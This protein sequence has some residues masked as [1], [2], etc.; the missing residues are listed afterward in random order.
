MSYP[1]CQIKKKV[2]EV[3]KIALEQEPCGKWHLQYLP[4][5]SMGGTEVS[6]LASRTKVLCSGLN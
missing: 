2:Q 6:P 4:T 1:T 5:F 3:K